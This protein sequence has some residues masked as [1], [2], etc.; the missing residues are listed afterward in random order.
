LRA[1]VKE[2]RIGA[3]KITIRHSIPSTSSDPTPGTYCDAV[4]QRA[5]AVQGE[6]RQDDG[7]RTPLDALGAAL[8]T[9][10]ETLAGS[11]VTLDTPR[12]LPPLRRLQAALRDQPLPAGHHTVVLTD[13]LVDATDTLTDVVRRLVEDQA[14]QGRGR[15]P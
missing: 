1:V 15:A 5:A 8:G 11:L 14:A 3:D 4:V 12:G 10:L 7:R 2:V 13:C 9:T 6:E